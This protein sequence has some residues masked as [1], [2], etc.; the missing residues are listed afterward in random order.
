VQRPAIVWY[1]S[2]CRDD[3]RLTYR[4][5]KSAPPAAWGF[6]IRLE[7]FVG[8]QLRKIFCGSAR[9]L[10]RHIPN[11]L[12]AL[13]TGLILCRILITATRGSNMRHLPALQG[14]RDWQTARRALRNQLPPRN[15]LRRPFSGPTESKECPGSK[16][17]LPRRQRFS[18][19][20]SNHVLRLDS[21][22]WSMSR[23][24]QSDEQDRNKQQ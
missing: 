22:V 9:A 10:N 19:P 20:Q 18:Q 13:G 7:P 1:L 24:S 14:H 23:D 21:F 6:G 15:T 2:Q 5:Q 16:A 8:Q 3:I 11:S 12:V 17:W 4:L